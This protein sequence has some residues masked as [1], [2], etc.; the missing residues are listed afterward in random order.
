MIASGATPFLKGDVIS[1]KFFVEAKTKMQES[2]S[3]SVKKE[4]MDKARAQAFSTGK[5]GYSVAISFGDGKDYYILEDTT[6]IELFR[7]KA[8]L[9]AVIEMLGGLNESVADNSKTI[10]LND[11]K[12]EIRRYL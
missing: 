10:K 3:I 2:K 7:E 8:A 5:E 1:G 12:T 11:I 9:D 4:W 6:F